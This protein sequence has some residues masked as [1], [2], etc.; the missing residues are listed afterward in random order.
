A[1]RVDFDFQ[2][3]DIT[4]ARVGSHRYGI[5]SNSCGKP[6]CVFCIQV[7]GDSI[8]QLVG[9]FIGGIRYRGC[10]VSP[11]AESD[12][13][14]WSTGFCPRA[15]SRTLPPAKGLPADNSPGNTAVDIQVA[16]GNLLTPSG[17]FFGVQRVDAGREP[18]RYGVDIFDGILECVG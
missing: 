9:Q 8:D 12:E 14:V 10:V 6:L 2:I 16:G 1:Q 15:D 11:V 17:N 5:V 18:I 4:L 3:R 7:W 13:V